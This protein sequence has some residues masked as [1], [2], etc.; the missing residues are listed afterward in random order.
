MKRFVQAQSRS[1]C[2]LF[3]ELVDDFIAEDNPVRVIDVFDE[4]SAPITAIA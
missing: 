4:L 1:Q 2:T 3:P